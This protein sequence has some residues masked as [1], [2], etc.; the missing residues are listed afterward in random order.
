M[1]NNSIRPFPIGTAIIAT[2][3]GISIGIT[4]GRIFPI[5]Q[6]HSTSAARAVGAS[7]HY[8]TPA[9]V[10]D[11]FRFVGFGD[12]STSP[13]PFATFEFT[14]DSFATPAPFATFEFTHGSFAA[15]ASLAT[16]E[17]DSNVFDVPAQKFSFAQFAKVKPSSE[18]SMDHFMA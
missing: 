13:T 1:S 5:E 18:A 10:T 15:P 2:L 16:F 4:I 12:G 3:I 11:H 8:G 7:T 14:H 17:F 9:A 6:A